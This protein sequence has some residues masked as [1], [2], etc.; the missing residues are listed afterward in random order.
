MQDDKA[1]RSRVKLFGNL[2]GEILKDQ[3]GETVFN[4]VEQLRK[5][6]ISLHG[7]PNAAQQRELMQTIAQLDPDT[8]T[9]VIRA[10]ST[11]FSLSN[12]AEEAYQHQQRRHR[13]QQSS[14]WKGSF[15]AVLQLLKTQGVDGERLQRLLNTLTFSPV[16]TAHPTEARRRT[17]MDALRRIFTAS[18]GLDH[19]GLSPHEYE[20]ALAALKCQIQILWKTDEVRA[21]R[22]QV[23]D[24][25]NNGLHYFTES[26][27]E[28]IPALYR[29]LEKAIV[30]VYGADIAATIHVPSFIQFG[31]WI[32]GDRDGNPFVK[33]ETTVLALYLQAERVLEE[34]SRRVVQLSHLFSQSLQICRLQQNPI[35]LSLEQDRA[36][37]AA[38]FANKP[39]RSITEPFRRKLQIMHYRLQ[40]NLHQVRQQLTRLQA[41][42]HSPSAS[43]E[44]A[45]DP[46]ADHQ[47]PNSQAFLADLKLVQAALIANRDEMITQGDL[48]DLIRL[49]ETCGFH[50]LKLDIRQESSRHTQAVHE[51]LQQQGILDYE[52][53]NETQRLEQLLT[54]L[55]TPSFTVD[56]N[57]LSTATREVTDV[58]FIMAQ[59]LQQFS[60][61]AFGQ[62]IISMTHH[63]SN[64]LEVLLLAKIAGLVS[65]KPD[66]RCAIRISPL[67]ETI[68]DLKRV[69]P[70]LTTLLDKIP[71]RHWLKNSGNQQEVML[72]YSDSCKDGGILASAW[73][74]YE[75]QKKIIDIT[76]GYNIKCRLFHGRGGTIGRGG[77]PTYDAIVAQPPGTVHGNIKFTEQGE[78]L[79]YQY[80]N[81]ETA[82]Y[83]LTM[84]SSG[85]LMA[86][87][88]LVQQAS[89]E[90]QDYL[91]VMDE[92]AVLGEQAYREL[93][94]ETEGLLDYFYEATPVNEIGLMNIGSRPSH[95]SKKD[96]SKASI[97]AIPWVFGWAQSRH[98]LPA[99]YGIGSALEKWRQRDI[100]RLAKLQ[101]MYQ[102]WPFFNTLLSN[103]Q[104]SLAKAD[105]ETA[106]QYA[107]LCKN[108]TQ[109]QFIY[110]TIQ[111]EYHRTITQVLHVT[112]SA[113]LLVDSPE[114]ERSLKR[115]KPYLDPLNHIQVILLQRYRDTTLPPEQRQ[116]WLEPL[117]RTINA[118][119]AGMRNTG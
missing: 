94:D 8:L 30:E 4:A 28:A 31:S 46:L 87:C 106:Q 117:L 58:F 116:Q 78:V 25:I 60:T 108:T 72:G 57:A 11:Y 47:Y 96:R 50:L 10:F 48:Q 5:G 9:C 16:F 20:Q 110:Q 37:Q 88:F 113:H 83:E 68:D 107:R 14:H 76:L 18:Q 19:P 69:E 27:F 84:G 13:L 36:Y 34:Y 55:E 85:L 52:Q 1:L 71:Y 79:S 111:R 101:A 99:W 61:H 112:N 3:A 80:S 63:A 118:I 67:F 91:G 115:R 17:I 119:A 77:G 39:E 44:S 104:M 65:G 22:P 90:R 29:E 35:M 41:G 70:V 74:L 23:R 102:E 42:V 21:H 15:P 92:L 62:Y 49:V 12:I 40:K 59:I 66:Y 53:Q 33:P 38:A 32:G 98:T 56:T 7:Q 109:A 64:I 6:F 114:L 93:V 97:R 75:A 105:I 43:A 89:Q 54:L 103:V 81:V 100:H 95:R 24:E 51:I 82:V 2:L 26:L 86:S 45:A 73:N